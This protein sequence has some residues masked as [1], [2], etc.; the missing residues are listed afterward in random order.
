MKKLIQCGAMLLLMGGFEVACQAQSKEETLQWIKQ[1]L[2]YAKATRTTPGGGP[3]GAVAYHDVVA[4]GC[5]LTFM[6]TETLGEGYKGTTESVVTVP[7]GKLSS[8]D[9]LNGSD[10]G[11]DDSNTVRLKAYDK[12]ITWKW[13]TQYIE[14]GNLAQVTGREGRA[15]NKNGAANDSVYDIVLSSDEN[16]AQRLA[17]ALAHANEL[18]GGKKEAF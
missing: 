17:K 16:L 10:G 12:I 15:T 8:A 4:N 2:P 6:E 18:C 5:S 3:D 7:L 1:R 9:F 13:T 14:H 11:W